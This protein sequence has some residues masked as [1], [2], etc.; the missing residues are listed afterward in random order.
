MYEK[1]N[2]FLFKIHFVHGVHFTKYKKKLLR[3]LALLVVRQQV[4]KTKG[5][6]TG[7]N[8]FGLEKFP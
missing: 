2:N 5:C 8:G 1:T 3:H 4:N 6:K 7:K